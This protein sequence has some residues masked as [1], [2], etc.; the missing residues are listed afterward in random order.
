MLSVIEYCRW[1][2]VLAVNGGLEIKMRYRKSVQG[3]GILLCVTVM[4][5]CTAC[6]GGQTEVDITPTQDQTRDVIKET[7]TKQEAVT[8]PEPTTKPVVGVPLVSLYVRNETTNVRERTEEYGATF[9]KGKDIVSFEVFA[10][11]V[12]SFSF[13]GKYFDGAWNQYWESYE[14]YE[15][16]KI[17]YIVDFALKDGTRIKKTITHPDDVFS[18]RNYLECYLYDDVN[19]IQ[20]NWYSH[21]LASQVDENTVMTSIKFTA[22]QDIAMVGDTITLTAFVYHSEDDFDA[23]GNYIGRVIATAVVKDIPQ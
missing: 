2:A 16:C 12:P 6:K 10:T 3:F 19:Q 14:G 1:T 21:L 13:G 22:G 18:Y 4:F 8:N 23:D 15:Q 11:D 5:C 7:E 20:G 9:V 17:G